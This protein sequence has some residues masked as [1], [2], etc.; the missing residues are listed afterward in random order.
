MGRLRGP[1]KNRL[2]RQSVGARRAFGIFWFYAF[3]ALVLLVMEWQRSTLPAEIRGLAGDVVSPVLRLLAAPIGAAQSGI[4]RLAGVSS[5]YL[6]NDALKE[7]NARLKQWREAARQL[8]QENV[9]LRRLLN[10]PKK[11]ILY[12]TVNTKK[13]ICVIY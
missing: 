1:S 10:S 7:E 11:E 6:E 4:E 8:G 2:K 13:Q 9:H 12:F 3:V 5:I